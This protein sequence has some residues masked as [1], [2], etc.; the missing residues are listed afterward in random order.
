MNNAVERLYGHDYEFT[1]KT[2]YP[3]DGKPH[4]IQLNLENTP[5]EIHFTSPQQTLSEII[6]EHIALTIVLIIVFAALIIGIIYI[7]VKNKR[8][9]IYLQKKQEQEHNEMV[10]KQ[11]AQQKEI[12]RIENN[13]S[14]DQ[15]R[16]KEEEIRRKKHE[17]DRLIVEAM[18]EAGGGFLP[19]L[20]SDEGAFFISKPS[21]SIG[22][23]DGC[24]FI[25][26]SQTVSRKHAEILFERDTYFIRDLN[27]SNGTFVNGKKISQTELRNGDFIE[28]GE[29]KIKFQF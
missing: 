12:E 4:I 22:R 26:K 10:E 29:I 3:K 23:S 13:R 20:V 24:D 19:Q 6:A 14:S 27:S 5:K 15:L 16:Q 17:Q 9:K 11:A 2:T 21:I 28:F 18:V 1:Y 25:I 7:N 8:Q